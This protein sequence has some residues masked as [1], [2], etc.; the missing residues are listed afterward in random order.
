MRTQRLTIAIIATIKTLSP[1]MLLEHPSRRLT[2]NHDPMLTR[3]PEHPH[4]DHATI[5]AQ[6]DTQR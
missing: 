4:D 6:D 3:N 5:M 1:P 2:R